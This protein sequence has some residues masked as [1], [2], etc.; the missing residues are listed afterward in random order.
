[1]DKVKVNQS[2]KEPQMEKPVDIDQPGTDSVTE[3]LNK[4]RTTLK[5]ITEGV[6]RKAKPVAQKVQQKIVEKTPVKIKE[7]ITKKPKFGWVKYIFIPTFIIFVALIM[8]SLV[9]NN[10]ENGGNGTDPEPTSVEEPTPTL[11]P[12]G[13]IR[14]SIYSEDKEIQEIQEQINVL[15]NEMFSV[16]LRDSILNP[17]IL[18]FNI[19]FKQQ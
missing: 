9:K 5:K 2:L 1:M 11:E 12:V 8:Y 15:N 10:V 7:K 13:P 3:D 16:P 19:S 4:F 17:P 18:D 14:Q 6:Q